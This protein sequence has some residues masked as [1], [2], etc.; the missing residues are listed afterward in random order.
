VAI[1]SR[2]KI[3]RAQLLTLFRDQER[4][5]ACIGRLRDTARIDC[6][7]YIQ[8]HRSAFEGYE[9]PLKD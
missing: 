5:D 7:T 8:R 1:G 4:L 3:T 9:L 6:V 2:V